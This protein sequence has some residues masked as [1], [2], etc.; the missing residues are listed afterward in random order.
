MKYIKFIGVSVTL[1]ALFSGCGESAT[2]DIKV[3]KTARTL[4]PSTLS[5]IQDE[6]LN[7]LNSLRNSAGMIPFIHNIQLE[8]ASNNHAKYLTQNNLFSHYEST[9]YAGFTG[10]EPA[11]R[12]TFVGYAQKNVGE[13]ISSSNG[14]VQNSIDT[15]FS[16]IY[17]RFAFLNFDYDEIGIGF[18]QSA[19]YGYE[20]VYNYSMGLSALRTLCESG[21]SRQETTYY[22]G[23]CQD[24]SIQIGVEAYADVLSLNKSYNPDFVIWPSHGMGSVPPVF[25]EESPDPLPE[26]SVS[27]YPISISFNP[28]KSGTIMIDSFKLYDSQN[29]E[30]THVKLMDKRND[31]NREFTDKE[32][33]LFPMERLSWD[34]NY[35]V[36][37]SYHDSGVAKQKIVDFKTASLPYPM[38]TVE[39]KG[40]VL[41]APLNQTTMFYLPPANCQDTLT[42]FT[43]TGVVA[44]I[45][46]HDAN[47]IMITPK[48]KGK[49]EVFPSNGR[50]FTIEVK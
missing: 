43:T 41:E 34:S 11:D 29:Q 45:T 44:E 49:L 36:E 8:S 20:N 31:P 24:K 42:T 46:F 32:F 17:H 35:H 15:L 21:G 37:I 19:S 33:A 28:L 48:A 7:Y 47:T 22:G 18:S 13:N 2:A 3:D 5:S 10:V 38:Q 14:S 4:N 23:I 39:Q 9:L 40:M 30:L 6:G 26:C 25:Y 1:A 12:A 27:G 16:A 50:D